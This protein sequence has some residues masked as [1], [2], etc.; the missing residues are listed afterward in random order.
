MLVLDSSAFV[1]LE[2]ERARPELVAA[3]AR[4]GHWVV[5]EHFR[6]EVFSAV[7][8]AWLGGKIGDEELDRITKR[9]VALDLDVWPTAPLL[10]RIRELAGNATAYDAAYLALA[11]E[12]G[13][14]LVTADAKFATVPG[15]RCRI[16]GWGDG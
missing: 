8:G 7:R 15:I 4:T 11:E 9:L 6:I 2:L 13:G 3:M 16:V 12:V 5:P 10:P 14:P 1:D